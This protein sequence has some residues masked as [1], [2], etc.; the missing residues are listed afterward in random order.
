MSQSHTKNYEIVNDIEIHELR[1][2]VADE[3]FYNICRNRRQ[4]MNGIV[5]E[6]EIQQ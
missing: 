1:M 6:I 5:N 2:S 3:I 4:I